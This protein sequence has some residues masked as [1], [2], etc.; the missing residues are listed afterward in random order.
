MNEI[1]TNEFNYSELDADTAN[2]LKEKESNM[3][4]VVNNASEKI[5]KELYEAQQKLSNNRNG[6]FEKWYTALGFK[7]QSVYN[8]INRY[9]YIVQNLDNKKQIETFQELPPSLQNEVSKK[10]AIPELNQAVFNGDIKTHKE[11]KEMERKLKEAEEAKAQAERQIE[12]LKKSEQAAIERMEELEEREPKVVEKEVVPDDYKSLKGNYESLKRVNKIYEEQN[13]QLRE[14]LE[15]LDKERQELSRKSIDD[16]RL[17]CLR[18]RER[19]L[20]EKI[21][22]SY[23][24]HEL[25][26]E[27]E[28]FISVISPAKHTINFGRISNEHDLLE[29]FEMTLDGIIKIC[30]EYKGMLPNKNIIEGEIL[31]G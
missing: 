7:K 6:V 9:Q 16:S 14:E 12:A 13:Q 10:S 24:L 26:S 27:M 1:R 22:Q 25:Q 19:Q 4:N 11:Y 23:K 20:N 3:R 2:Y 15:R 29:S 8:Y 17:E 31:N 28:K 5:G 18:E 30:Q 21:N